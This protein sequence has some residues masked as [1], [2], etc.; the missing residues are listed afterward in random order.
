[1]NSH[2]LDTTGAYAIGKYH[3]GQPV[4]GICLVFPID[5][6]R[7]ASYNVPVVAVLIVKAHG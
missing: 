4:V 5:E 6:V 3:A 7:G 2:Y 1:M